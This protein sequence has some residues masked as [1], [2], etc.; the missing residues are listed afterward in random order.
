M[1]KVLF[2]SVFLMFFQIGRA[3]EKFVV[4]F[5]N[6]KYDLNKVEQ[7]KFDKWIAAN[8]TSKILSITGST[9]EVG[10]NGFND[11]LSQK[12][13]NTIYALVNGKLKIRKDF[14]SISLGEKG[15]T[16]A[17]KAENRKAIIHYLFEKDLAREEEILGI[18]PKV[19]QEEEIIPIEEERM[20]FPEGATLQDKIELSTKG[21]L[22]R[23]NNI[24]FHINT[25]AVMANS[26]PSISELVRV[27]DKYPKIKIE[28]QGHICCVDKDVKNLSLDRAKQIKRILVYEGIN[29][30]RI[31][32]RGFGV[33]KPKFPISE[34][35]EFEAAQN[36]RVEIMILDK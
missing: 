4:Y 12:R 36:R 1:K 11:T 6:N 8:K 28:I 35:T 25:F 20:H 33:S 34:K 31:K 27:L 7:A 14:K 13:V 32:V 26:K 23:L 19:V 10:S 22:I 29:E 17:N 9:D 2:Y 30:R 15:A 24:N 3:Q 18:T 5:D 16:S 21:T